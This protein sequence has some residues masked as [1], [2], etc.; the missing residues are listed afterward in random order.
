M[1]M[2]KLLSGLGSTDAINYC[3]V[4][5][6][7]TDLARIVSTTILTAVDNTLYNG[8][9]INVTVISRILAPARFGR[10]AGKR[11]RIYIAENSK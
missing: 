3:C 9:V 8:S 7:L 10:R 6:E 4:Q 5:V 11:R 1:D 2:A